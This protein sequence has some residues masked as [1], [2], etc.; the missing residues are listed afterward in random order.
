[1]STEDKGEQ[2]LVARFISGTFSIGA[3]T[4][5]NAVL[6]LLGFM[7]IARQ[8]GQADL[9]SYVLVTVIA[10][11][12][13]QISNF[14]LEPA[15]ANHIS[16]ID[17]RDQ[18]RRLA[19][20]ALFFRLGVMILV[21]LVA[22]SAEGLL[23]RLFG[24][25]SIRELSVFILVL[26]FLDGW[27]RLQKSVLQGLFLFGRIGAAT[28]IYSSLNFVLLIV[29]VPVLQTG[30][31]GVIYAKAI[32]NLVA[33]VFLYAYTPLAK[34]IEFH[35]AELKSMIR[36]GFPLQI[37]TIFTFIFNRIDTVLI[38][39]L[40]GSA[41]T[42]YYEV[43][44]KIPDNISLFYE[45]FRAVY[46]PLIVRFFSRGDRERV[47]NLLNASTRLISVGTA[48]LALA[49]L[50]FGR[51][52]IPLLFSEKY[53][54][55]LP[56]FVLLMTAL[57]ISL[58]GYTLGTSLVAIGDTSKPPIINVVHIAASL[59]ANLLL[60]P[61]A[62]IAGAGLSAVVGPLAT[63]PLNVFFLVRNGIHVDVMSYVK[64]ILAFSSTAGIY[65]LL[66]PDALL[67]KLS[68][69]GL[70]LIFCFLLSCVKLEEI[71]LLYV[72]ARKLAGRSIA[73]AFPRISPP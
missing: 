16:A 55:S 34:R 15:L 65:L 27:N 47:S 12:L 56:A 51:Q 52:L 20:T 4:F 5:V 25:G 6:S 43:A 36:F 53:L 17:D 48:A 33:D 38:A 66:S 59:G 54:P 72:E 61:A 21:G 50:V 32:S 29:L 24:G 64:P 46:F 37:N 60:I 41:A 42:A 35:P 11:F 10:T 26:Y 19:N 8:I 18:M 69:M 30:V 67:Y 63:N 68:L 13:T 39:G 40:L 1:M 62:G 71:R 28:I 45:S 58:I 70:S 73:K 9:G 44:R 22:T 23:F 57:S 14:G 31:L 3:G 7:I 49:A 2:T